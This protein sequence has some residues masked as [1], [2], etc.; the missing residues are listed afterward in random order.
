VS[1]TDFEPAVPSNERVL[2]VDQR[3]AVFGRTMA[4]VGAT[5]GVSA[6]GAWAGKELSFGW[7]IAFY[8]AGFAC[9]IGLSFARNRSQTFSLTLL[10]AMGALLGLGLGPTITAYVEAFGAGLVAQAAG[11]TAL[12]IAGFGAW[13]YATRRDLAPLARMAFFGLLALIAFGI[14]AIFVSIPAEQL[15]WCI[16]GLGLFAIFTMYDF[17]RLKAAHPDDA[18]WLAA[19]IFV[20]VLNVFLFMLQLLAMGRD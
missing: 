3:R 5:V 20:D 18:V 2:T 7:A 8:I 16:V 6:L 10:F 19:S 4:L 14:V 15:I 1:S 9:L 11:A 12:F 13:G 17:Q